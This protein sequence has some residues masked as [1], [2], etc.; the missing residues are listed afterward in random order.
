[1]HRMRSARDSV[2]RAVRVSQPFRGRA[3]PANG[4]RNGHHVKKPNRNR[5]RRLSQ[6]VRLK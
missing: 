4:Q 6:H 3:G 1:R 2:L 5:A